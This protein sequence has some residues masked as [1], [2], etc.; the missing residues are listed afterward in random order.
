MD[1]GL[2]HCT[3]DSDEEHPQ[4]KEKAKWLSVEAL[5]IPEEKEAKGQGE[6]ESYTP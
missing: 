2:R 1:G 4:G 5:Q 3:G 6:K